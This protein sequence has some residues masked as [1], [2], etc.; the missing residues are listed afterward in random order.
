QSYVSM[1]APGVDVPSTA[2]AG[3]GRGPYASQSGT[4]IA[5]PHVAGA[6]AILWALRPDLSADDIANALENNAD[7]VSSTDPGYGA[8][9]LNVA[10]AVAALRLGITPKTTDTVTLQPTRPAAADI[11]P[12]PPLP[13]E[14]RRWYFAE[15]STRAPFSVSFALQNPN[16]V[17]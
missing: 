11:P 10:R 12:P 8:G 2:W 13:N 7:K 16:P 17:A 6:A 4:S 3:A 15:G 9:I 1:A 5:A 14:Q